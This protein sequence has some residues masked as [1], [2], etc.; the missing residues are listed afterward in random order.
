MPLAS[1]PEWCRIVLNNFF[2][3]ATD[4]RPL[5]DDVGNFIINS[6]SS[7]PAALIA[8]LVERSHQNHLGDFQSPISKLSMYVSPFISFGVYSYVILLFF[9]LIKSTPV[10]DYGWSLKNGMRASGP[11]KLYLFLRNQHTCFVWLQVPDIKLRC[12]SVVASSVIP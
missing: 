10:M 11:L 5:A 7:I 3:M 4:M 1:K 12:W 6:G 8:Q 9:P 2:G